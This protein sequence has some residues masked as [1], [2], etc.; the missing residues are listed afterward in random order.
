MSDDDYSKLV[1]ESLDYMHRAIDQCNQIWDFQSY[2][3][4]DLDL[5]RAVLSFSDGP[6][7][8][9]DCSIQVVGI[10][11]VNRHFWRWSW[12]NPSIEVALRGD[13]EKV[14]QFGEENAIAELTIGGWEARDEEAA[15]HMTAI[16]SKLLQ[17]TSVYR[18]P[19]PPRH[20]FLLV[21]GVRWA[22]PSTPA[23][24]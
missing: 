8:P 23:A 4:W 16:A 1:G 13:I 21:T 15:W 22:N 5:N 12:D 3:R 19:D 14:R 6:R 7:P 9:I 10:Y 11:M 17:A 20:V 18:G 2:Q 24:D